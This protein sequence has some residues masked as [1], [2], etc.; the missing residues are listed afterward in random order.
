MAVRQAESPCSPCGLHCSALAHRK[1]CLSRWPPAGPSLVCAVPLARAL[2]AKRARANRRNQ[3]RS[4]TPNQTP[5]A[6]LDTVTSITRPSPALSA[7]QSYL[8]QRPH[9]RDPWSVSL[10]PL[11]HAFP[12]TSPPCPSL[13][14]TSTTSSAPPSLTTAKPPFTA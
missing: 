7:L 8:S 9:Q 14:P 3:T 11:C 2:L 4:T 12:S 6:L 13:P 10:S 5:P 1:K